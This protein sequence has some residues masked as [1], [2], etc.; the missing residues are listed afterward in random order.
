[1]VETPSTSQGFRDRLARLGLLPEVS[2]RVARFRERLEAENERQNLTR[3]LGE[4]EFVE[5]HLLDCLELLRSGFLSF[6]AMDLGSGGGVPGLLAAAL[7]SGPW[8]LV[9]SEAAKAEFL[10]RTARELELD[11]QV[12]VFAERGG[13]VLRRVSVE[14]VVSRAVGKVEKIFG[15]IGE[16]STWNTLVLL[17]GPGWETE[18]AEFQ[19]SKHRRRLRLQGEHRYTVGAE[20]KRRVIV[21]LTRA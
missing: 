18:W 12:S 10:S 16:C 2:Q 20:A 21:R 15:W 8:V 6:P 9:E 4:D 5:G 11:R 3:I 1:M 17:K 14:T 13:V 19:R 7:G